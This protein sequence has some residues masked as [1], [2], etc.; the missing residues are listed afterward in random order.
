MVERS[1]VGM[2]AL[3]GGEVQFCS[4]MYYE[5]YRFYTARSIQKMTVL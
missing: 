1:G 3:W 4:S 5:F 2:V